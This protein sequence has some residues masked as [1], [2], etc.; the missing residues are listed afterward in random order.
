MSRVKPLGLALVAAFALSAFAATSAFA[1][2]VSILT[3]AGTESNEVRISGKAASTATFGILEGFATIKCGEGEGEGHQEGKTLLGVGHGQL[4]KCTTSA[5]GTCTGLNDSVA[6][7]I[8]VLGTTHIVIVSRSPL[9]LGILSLVEHLHFTCTKVSGFLTILVLVKGQYLCGL[10]P[11]TLGTEK[12][13]T[14][15]G[16]SGDAENTTYFNE[17][18]KEVNIGTEALL[19]SENEGTF[20]MSA[21]EGTQE[22]IKTSESVELMD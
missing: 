16:K 6:G 4:T 8:L 3:A 10:T 13:V 9:T 11:L 12:T 17:E 20:K 19:T 1:G 14:C 7:T 5:G 2:E 21:L 15:R 18:G 22:H